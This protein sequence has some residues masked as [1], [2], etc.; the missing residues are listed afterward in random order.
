[1]DFGSFYQFRAGHLE[2]VAENAEVALAV[3]DSWLVSDGRVRS[4]QGHY[5]RFVEGVARLEFAQNPSNVRH[6][7]IA[8]FFSAVI[9]LVPT[10]GRWFPRVEF[11][12]G[13]ANP[14]FVKLREAPEQLGAATLW[15]LD[16]PDP[17]ALPSV[18]GPDLSLCMQL[19]RKAQVHGADEAALL[20]H[21]GHIVEGA[22]SSLV[23]WRDDVLEAPD[24]STSWLASITRNEVFAIAQQLGHETREVASVEAGLAGCE[25]WILSSLHGVRQV[26]R[27]IGSNG[28]E[29]AVA[30]I[31]PESTKRVEAFQR[32]L[33]ML[34]T[35]PVVDR[36]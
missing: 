33:R 35:V 32:R 21:A 12:A 11:H 7:E 18:K 14:L 30:P 1:M 13:E 24:Q 5:D 29:I 19:R 25:V 4:M 34:S 28:S 16:E 15:S 26:S 27:W 9:A 22:L 2:Q 6:G 36:D 23:W 17:R 3:A 20:D 10:A 8:D 31:S